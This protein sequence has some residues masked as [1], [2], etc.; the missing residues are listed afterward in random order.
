MPELS[1]V[2]FSLSRHKVGVIDSFG[3]QGQLNLNEVKSRHPGAYVA[4]LADKLEKLFAAYKYD[5]LAVESAEYGLNINSFVE[6]DYHARMIGVLLLISN[7]KQMR[8][9]E[10]LP[11]E[12]SQIASGKKVKNRSEYLVAARR[13]SVEIKS[14]SEFIAEAYWVMRVAQKSLG[15]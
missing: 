6:A 14:T 11:R 7:R 12:V 2:A 5:V 3:R 9:V 4:S 1:I 15:R 10:V 13:N 8:F